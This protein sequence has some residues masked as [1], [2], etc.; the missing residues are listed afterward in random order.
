MAPHW[1]G[2]FRASTGSSRDGLRTWYMALVIQGPG[3]RASAVAVVVHGGRGRLLA[4]VHGAGC[5]PDAAGVLQQGRR[6]QDL[7]G[8]QAGRQGKAGQAGH[9]TMCVRQ[10]VQ[11]ERREERRL[12]GRGA[13]GA[14]WGTHT[15]MTGVGR[16]TTDNAAGR[17]GGWPA[18]LHL[19]GPLACRA[20]AW[21]RGDALDARR[22]RWHS[23]LAVV[24]KGGCNSV[25]PGGGPALLFLLLDPRRLPGRGYQLALHAFTCNGKCR[26]HQMARNAVSGWYP[27]CQACRHALCPPPRPACLPALCHPS[28]DSLPPICPPHSLPHPQ[29]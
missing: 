26:L 25:M 15:Y 18:P 19:R 7:A 1:R 6:F 27:L 17:I 9:D 13:Q 11:E 22:H 10:G 21:G 8:G 3:P 5:A 20:Q 28:L 2:G 23:C 29:G 14:R 16:Q 12:R 24:L 4:E